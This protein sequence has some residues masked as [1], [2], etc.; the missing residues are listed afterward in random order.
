MLLLHELNKRR[1]GSFQLIAAH[2]DHM[3][4]GEESFADLAFV[5]AYCKE[6]EILL[7]RLVYRSPNMQKKTV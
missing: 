1:K 4:R 6:H 7:N 2:V 5:E 3:F